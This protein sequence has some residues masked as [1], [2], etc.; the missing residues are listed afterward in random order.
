MKYHRVQVWDAIDGS[1][2]FR[3]FLIETVAEIVS[4]ISRYDKSFFTGLSLEGGQATAGGGFTNTS[5]SAYKN[6][7]KGFLIEN[8]LESAL[9]AHLKDFNF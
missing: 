8:V 6:P 9:K 7:M 2:V 1:G 4:R 3:D 5:F